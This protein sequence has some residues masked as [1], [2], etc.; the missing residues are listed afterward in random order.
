MKKLK[1]KLIEDD[2]YDFIFIVEELNILFHCHHF[3]SYEYHFTFPE[4]NGEHGDISLLKTIVPSFD[5]PRWKWKEEC[6]KEL[7]NDLNEAM[8]RDD[9]RHWL[10]EFIFND[11]IKFGE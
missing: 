3:A 1:V 6:R 5:E 2:G 11:L 7:E 4:S 8:Q 9:N 10:V